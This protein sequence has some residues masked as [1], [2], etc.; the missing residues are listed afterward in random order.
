[1]VEA[2]MPAM[3]AIKSATVEAAKLLGLTDLGIIENGKTADIV[4]I[5]GD[6]LTDIKKMKEMRFVMKE[7]V[8]YKQ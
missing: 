1:M 3:V 8:I 6:P 4:A 2:G 7:G 5:E